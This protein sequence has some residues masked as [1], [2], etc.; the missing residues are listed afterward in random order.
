MKDEL[1]AKI[2]A[3]KAEAFQSLPALKNLKELQDFKVHLL[4][5]KGLLTE[6][7]KGLG[8][9]TPEE[10]PLVGQAANKIKTEI[11]SQLE[12]L[13]QSLETKEREQISQAKLL[14]ITLPGLQLSQGFRHPLSLVQEELS[15]IFLNLGFSIYEGPEVEAD[16]YNF[17]ALNFPADHPA[18]EMQDTF[19]IRPWTMDHGLRTKDEQL[20]KVHGLQSIVHGLMLL[21]THTSPVQIRAMKIQKPPLYMIAPGAVYRHDDDVT[22]SPMFHQIEGL[23]VDTHITFADLKGVLTLV[24]Q[25]IFGKE[26]KVRFRPSFF[27]FV[28]PGAEVDVSCGLCD[29][30]GCRVCGGD[31][32]LEILG[33]GMVH[34]AV[35]KE[36]GVDPKKY[37]GFAFGMGI[38]RIAMLKYGID[39]IR[40]FYQSDLRFLEQF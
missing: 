8:T 28:E 23:M 18:R 16:Y 12:V 31:G 9:L 6:I 15:S 30:K 29:G 13:Q 11:E 40:L 27:P 21:R 39:D 36:T 32:W 35:L 34:P 1:L 10:R 24:C 3:L 17:E 14:D 20:E 26:R 37:T 4:G 38:E 5:R 19:Y 22:H 25:T 33:A 2:E 7:L